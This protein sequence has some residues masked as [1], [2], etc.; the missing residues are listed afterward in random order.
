MFSQGGSNVSSL[1]PCRCAGL[2]KSKSKLIGNPL[3]R[4]SQDLVNLN[5]VMRKHDFCICENIGADQLHSYLISAFV[6]AT[7]IVRLLY[8]QNP[9]LQASS[10]LLWL[11]SPVCVGPGQKLRR[12]VFSRYGSFILYQ[13]LLPR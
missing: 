13:L 8:F 11:Y 3:H 2:L 4:F 1:C 10:D 9:K 5:R 7:K 6:F 12:Q